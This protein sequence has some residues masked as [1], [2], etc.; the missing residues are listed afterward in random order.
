LK[1]EKNVLTSNYLQNQKDLVMIV[2]FFIMQN[3]CIA[4]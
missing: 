3:L 1:P 4:L 2:L